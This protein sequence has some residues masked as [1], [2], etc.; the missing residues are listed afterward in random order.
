[1]TS[2]TSDDLAQAIAAHPHGRVPADL[3]REHIV[4]LAT[5]LFAERGF[6]QASMDELARRAGVSKPVIYDLVGSKEEL[7]RRCVA[8]A[9]DDL[10]ERIRTAV[11]AESDPTARIRAGAL[12]FFGF[13]ADTG[14]VYT[15]LLASLG[16]EFADEL[17]GTRARIA[18]LVSD[19][20][21]EGLREVGLELDPVQIDALARVLSGGLESLAV[22]W[23]DHPERTAEELADLIA[24]FA[25]PGVLAVATAEL[26][27]WPA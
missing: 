21:A 6:A 4:L 3:R 18:E 16:A 10:G 13:V 8:R 7:L 1:M 9:S 24:H 12:A 14:P 22:W 5:E 15:A 11:Q 17:A 20:T 27:R 25:T 23:S 19:L 2:A 26:P